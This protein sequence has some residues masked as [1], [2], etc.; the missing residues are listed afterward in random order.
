MMTSD[1]AARRAALAAAAPGVARLRALLAILRGPGGC[2]WDQE[3][4]HASLAPY[5]LEEAHE[6]IEAIDSGDP[7]HLC[8]ELGDLLLQV[9]FHAQIAEESG[10]FDLDAIAEAEVAKMVE[11]HP[12]VFA[13][14]QATSADDV[15]N[16]WE[17]RKHAR[18]PRNSIADGVPKSLSALVRAQTISARAASLGFDWLDVSELWPKLAEEQAELQAAIAEQD[19]DSCEEELG[20]LL[21]ALVNLARHLGLDAES[22]LR[23]ATTKFAARFDRMQRPSDGSRRDTHTRAAW[24]RAWD[25]AKRLG[26]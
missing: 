21:F 4:T 14:A 24:D 13:D 7:A 5:L 19:R 1:P 22:A 2:P 15:R 17:A 25:E 9:V 20:D 12:H 18:R 16:Q 23:R 11:R 8:E 26:S 3:Q 10:H 6:V